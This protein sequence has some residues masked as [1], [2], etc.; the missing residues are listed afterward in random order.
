MNRKNLYKDKNK[1]RKTK[2]LQ[3]KRYYDK[4]SNNDVNSREKYTNEEIEMILKHEIPDIELAK[5]I[6]R[7]LRAIQGKRSKLKNGY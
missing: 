5:K 6:G 1:W 4:H 2:N 7:S 3:K